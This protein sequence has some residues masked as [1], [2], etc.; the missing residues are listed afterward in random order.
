MKI[1]IKCVSKR[2]KNNLVLND[3]NI[4]F[5]GGKIYGLSGRNGSGKQFFLNYYAV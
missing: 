5:E 1:Y 2:Y 4:A 3:V